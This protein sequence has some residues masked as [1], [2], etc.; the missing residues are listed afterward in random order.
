MCMRNASKEAR[1]R[2]QFTELSVDSLRHLENSTP[3]RLQFG[4]LVH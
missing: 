1:L 2:I 3:S 4:Q